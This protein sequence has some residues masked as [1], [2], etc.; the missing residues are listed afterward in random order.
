M[1]SPY[2]DVLYINISLYDQYIFK[3]SNFSFSIFTIF[4]NFTYLNLLYISLLS[5]IDLWQ[6][7]VHISRKLSQNLHCCQWHNYMYYSVLLVHRSSQ[8]IKKYWIAFC[9]QL[10]D[11]KLLLLLI[12]CP[13]F[14]N[15]FVTVY[16]FGFI[17][18]N[19]NTFQFQSEIWTNVLDT[20]IKYRPI[21]SGEKKTQHLQNRFSHIYI[22]HNTPYY[23][24][25][26]TIEWTLW[27]W[28]LY[29]KTFYNKYCICLC[30]W[31]YQECYTA[32]KKYCYTSLHTFFNV[33]N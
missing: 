33:I 24:K 1:Q 29:L 20:V 11:D 8:L 27:W 18:F 2:I 14:C 22:Y 32:Q 23:I 31:L 21:H 19:F 16:C 7:L 10:K 12:T 9:L 28:K 5:Y 17:L 6:S 15:F 25:L 3:F 4:I 30:S 26:N 13:Y